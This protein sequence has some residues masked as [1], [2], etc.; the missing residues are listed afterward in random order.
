MSTMK[1]KWYAA[2]ILIG[3]RAKQGSQ[4]KFPVYENIV[5]FQAT[6]VEEVKRLARDLARSESEGDDDGSLTW[7]GRP[8]TASFLGVRKIVKCQD[9]TA[10]ALKFP[11]RDLSPG[12]GTEVSYS[13]LV[14]DGARN[15]E[16]LCSGAVVTVTQ[17][18]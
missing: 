2:H 7:R 8:A 13:L 16:K 18:E 3:I 5:L 1:K 14:V 15:L 10:R 17:K 4:R 6:D 12:N 9:S 11:K